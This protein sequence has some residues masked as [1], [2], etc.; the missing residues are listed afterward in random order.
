MEQGMGLLPENFDPTFLFA[1]KG[2]RT[3]DEQNYHCHEFFE[4]CYMQSGRGLYRLDGVLYEVQEGDIL[5]INS[6]MYHQSL[7]GEKREA[8]VQFYVGLTDVQLNGL[9]PNSFPLKDGCALIHTS[10]DLRLKLSKLCISMQ[11]ENE[12]CR[13]G[14]YYMMKT[15][16]IQMLLLVLRELEQQPKAGT[17]VSCS[18]ESVNRKY[19]VEKIVDYFEDHYDQKISLDRIAGNMYLSPFYISKIFKA[20]TGDTPIHYLIDIR[21]E[22]ARAFLIQEPDLSVQEVAMR[23]GYDDAYHFS[24]LFKKKFG[25]SPSA[26]RRE[27]AGQGE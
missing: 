2:I 7:M 22:K 19:L 11:V 6:G 1:W 26:Q 3:E 21:M 17:A 9:A 10:G 23:V 20:E 14:R 8:M 12:M 25:I 5:I 27:S 16:A 4:V 18:F 15:Y 24:K 13:T